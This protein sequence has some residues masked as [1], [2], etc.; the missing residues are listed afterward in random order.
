MSVV[1]V[2]KCTM[3]GKDSCKAMTINYHNATVDLRKKGM[4]I[5][6]FG[7]CKRANALRVSLADLITNSVS[8]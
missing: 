2:T 3:T 5:D 1:I 7:D 4:F 6:L 8:S